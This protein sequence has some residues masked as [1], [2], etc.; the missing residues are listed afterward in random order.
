MKRFADLISTTRENAGLS[1]EQLAARLGYANLQK[2]ARRIETIETGGGDE[3]GLV[4]RI[5]EVLEIPTAVAAEALRLDEKDRVAAYLKTMST[6]IEPVLTTRLMPAIYA[7]ESLPSDLRDPAEMEAM[8]CERAREMGVYVH[9]TLPSRVALWIDPTGR[10]YKWAEP[11]EFGTPDA[12][13]AWIGRGPLPRSI[14]R[15][16]LDGDTTDG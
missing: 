12:P 5:L 15:Q 1:R 6:P 16:L 11:D 9:L 10:V 2:G 3:T 4:A 13:S 7:T 14:F 8:A